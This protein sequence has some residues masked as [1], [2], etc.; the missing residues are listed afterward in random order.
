MTTLVEEI[1]HLHCLETYGSRLLRGIQDCITSDINE[2][3]LEADEAIHAAIVM[4]KNNKAKKKNVMLVGN[5]GS[6]S[7]VAHMHND[8]SKCN[9]IRSMVLTETSLLTAYTNDD[10][11]EV[12]FSSQVEL[13]GDPQDIL[14][15]VSSSGSSE[16]IL[17]AVRVA[18][19]KNMSVI[20]FSGFSPLNILRTIG[21]LNFYI[22]SS[23]YGMVELAHSIL[24]HY[25][26]DLLAKK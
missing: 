4:L 5:G 6:S 2:K 13:W 10:G 9:G 18:K 8:L 17:N 20:T 16:N 21:D 24:C 3:P 26:T 25:I 1:D 23:S 11:Y 7:L 12:A 22:P 19:K 14:I 15:A